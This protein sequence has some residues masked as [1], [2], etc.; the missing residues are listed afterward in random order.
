[1]K[2]LNSLVPILTLIAIILVSLSAS[3]DKR[4]PPPILPAPPIPTP[5]SDVRIIHKMSASPDTIY[6]DNNIT[7]STIKVEIRDGEGFG[8]PGQ[9]VKF[10]TA[11]I[12]RVL[13]DVATDS[14][15]IATTV[16]WDDGQSGIA[17]VTAIVRKFQIGRASCRER[18]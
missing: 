3:C 4:N 11:P 12:G 10:K 5:L 15:G 14:T 7:Y 16:F 1:M 2:K 18:V 8:V 13:A 6:A 9:M 17:T